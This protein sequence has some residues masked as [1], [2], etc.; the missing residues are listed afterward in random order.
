LRILS[1]M[2]SIL[3]C[4]LLLERMTQEISRISRFAESLTELAIHE[5]SPSFI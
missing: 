2:S 5:A 1:R 4:L 3:D